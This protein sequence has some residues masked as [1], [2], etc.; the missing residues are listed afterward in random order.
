M[1][2]ESRG[3][4]VVLDVHQRLYREM[5]ESIISQQTDMTVMPSRTD[6]TEASLWCA[7]RA[8]LDED[9]L[10]D[11]DQAQ[12]L[13]DERLV[14]IASFE[15]HEFD[16]FRGSCDRLLTEFPGLMIVAINWHAQRLCVLR[17]EVRCD[18]IPSSLRVMMSTIRDMKAATPS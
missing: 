5:L 8:V 9:P 15:E 7:L 10:Q 6:G 17:N 2:K 3:I 14:V 11:Q 4:R 1:E 16:D 12:S 13:P 18:P